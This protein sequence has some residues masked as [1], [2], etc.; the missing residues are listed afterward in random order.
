LRDSGGP[1][2]EITPQPLPALPIAL[3]A[4][5]LIGFLV[6][7]LDIAVR[8][9][10]RKI[11]DRVQHV[12]GYRSIGFQRIGGARPRGRQMFSIETGAVVL[13]AESCEFGFPFAGMSNQMDGFLSIA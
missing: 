8:T 3:A 2:P 13:L 9:R 11:V 5:K 6:E 7:S 12:L 1:R 10:G 4:K